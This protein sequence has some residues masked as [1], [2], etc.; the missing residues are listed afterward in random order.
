MCLWS[1]DKSPSEFIDENMNVIKTQYFH[2]N[3]QFLFLLR[4]Q[5]M[6][7]LLYGYQLHNATTPSELKAEH[8]IE[9]NIRLS[10]MKS[11]LN[12]SLNYQFFYIILLL[13][14]RKESLQ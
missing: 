14:L 10:S 11:V 4:L 5:W 12:S 6:E 8:L 2:I 3:Y 1:N 9:P 13:I 7:L